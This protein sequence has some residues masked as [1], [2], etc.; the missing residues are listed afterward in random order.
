MNEQTT[1]W[2]HLPNAAHIDWIIRDVEENPSDWCAAF[3]NTNL[4]VRGRD[5]F[6]AWC[7]AYYAA[8]HKAWHNDR[9]AARD[10]ACD[11]A[12]DADYEAARDVFSN[13]ARRA[14]RDACLALIAYDP[15]G[16]LFDLPLEQVRALAE[17]GDRVAVLMLPACEVRAIR[18]KVDKPTSWCY[19]THLH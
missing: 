3:M 4:V 6:T 16:A 12:L 1:A 13:A 18:D 15:A 5:R 11:A 14:A 8:W 9:D 2:S 17:Q 10:A 19:T 7:A